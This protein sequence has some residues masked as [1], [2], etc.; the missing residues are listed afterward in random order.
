MSEKPAEQ[1]WKFQVQ[2]K[3]RPEKDPEAFYNWYKDKLMPE[4]VR[5]VKKYNIPRYS[6]FYTPPALRQPWREEFDNRLQKPHWGI[7]DWDATT[8]YW[9]H[10]PD[11]IRKLQAD[12]EWTSRVNAM[13]EDWIASAVHISIGYETV[14][15]D[16][17]KVLNTTV[18]AD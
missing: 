11:D 1:L 9:V 6:V 10:H 16:D 15:F 12:P 14:Y 7:P 13:E 8:C 2:H 5:L 18:A 17:G 4:C 3:K